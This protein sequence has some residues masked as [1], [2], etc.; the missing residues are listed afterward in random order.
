MN[1]IKRPSISETNF[2]FMFLAM[3]LLTLGALVQSRDVN[4][5]LL[6]TEYVLV[7]L[8]NLLFLKLRGL[9][10][11]EN[12]RLNKISFKNIVLVILIT[13][14]AYPVVVFIQAIFIGIISIF[15][16]VNPS[17]VPVPAN[18]MQYFL[19]LFIIA[20]SP[21][22]CEEVMFRGTIMSAYERLGTKKS[23]IISALLFG[24]FHFTIL[25]LVGPLI[26]G[27]IFGIM[28]HKTNSL[29]SSIIGHTVNNALAVSILYFVSNFGD[30][31]DDRVGEIA[32]GG[33]DLAKGIFFILFLV[34]VCALITYRLMKRLTESSGLEPE[35][36]YKNEAWNES[37]NDYDLD[38][39]EDYPAYEEEKTPSVWGYLP[40]LVS[41][42]IFVFI[43]WKFIL[44]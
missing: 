10:L 37:D 20:L 43:N 28:V 17:G 44:I 24:L 11:K 13:I 40:L 30:Q 5:G 3:I 6:I 14:F 41:L 18:E 1:K 4:S 38:Y 2:F 33:A 36:Y 9:S 21:G 12:L 26:L 8:P 42:I 23:I 16:E 35:D 34:I 25:N 27:I 29:Y 7:L 32:L 15:K 31:V 22:I 39:R 19:S